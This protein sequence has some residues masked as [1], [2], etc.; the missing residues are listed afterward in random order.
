MQYNVLILY[1]AQYILLYCG[2]YQIGQN[3]R[4]LIL[5]LILELPG[6]NGGPEQFPDSLNKSQSGQLTQESQ[7][8]QSRS[9]VPTLSLLT[10]PR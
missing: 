8:Q 10:Q 7:F 4:G 2:K 9:S 5:I 6:L 3:D 1:S